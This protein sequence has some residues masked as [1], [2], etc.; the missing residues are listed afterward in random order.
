MKL[1]KSSFYMFF[2]ILQTFLILFS[3]CYTSENQKYYLSFC[4]DSLRYIFPSNFDLFFYFNSIKL[5]RPDRD[6]FFCIDK[7]VE[8]HDFEYFKRNVSIDLQ[9]LEKILKMISSL[10]GFKDIN[11]FQFAIDS[12]KGDDTRIVFFIFP[13]TLEAEEKKYFDLC[14]VPYIEVRFDTQLKAAYK[15]KSYLHRSPSFKSINNN[16]KE[17]N[18]T[19][20]DITQLTKYIQPIFDY[21]NI[22]IEDINKYENDKKIKL[23]KFICNEHIF[24]SIDGSENIEYELKNILNIFVVINKRREM[25]SHLEII[26]LKDL[27]KKDNKKEI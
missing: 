9:S 2:L 14:T 6:P 22:N 3:G 15:I 26:Q 1:V 24:F 13:C 8:V 10:Y 21:Y 18:F 19:N 4:I 17:L 23:R 25:V 16:E 27:Y 7:L 12:N 20:I 11:S 5:G